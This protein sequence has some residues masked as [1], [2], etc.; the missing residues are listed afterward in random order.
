MK[1]FVHRAIG[2]GDTYDVHTYVITM[3]NDL[4]E[5]SVIPR[6]R[7]NSSKVENKWKLRKH[8]Y[9]LYDRRSDHKKS[10][11]VSRFHVSLK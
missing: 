8:S 7:G 4:A 10:S 1:A 3:L 6:G 9:D 5:H 2:V 11:V